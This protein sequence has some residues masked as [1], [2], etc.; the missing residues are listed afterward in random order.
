MSSVRELIQ[1][2]GGVELFVLSAG[3]GYRNPGF[4]WEPERCTIA[5]NVLGSAAMVNVAGLRRHAIG[6]RRLLDGISET[7]ARQIARTIRRRR[8]RVYITKRWMLVAWLMRLAP[9][10]VWGRL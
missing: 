7:A 10:S 1:E 3:T 2:L 8:S 9:D 6:R 5:V 4:A